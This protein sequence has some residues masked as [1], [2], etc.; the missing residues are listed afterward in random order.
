VFG[1][2]LAIGDADVDLFLECEHLE[3]GQ[4]IA[5]AVDGAEGMTWEREWPRRYD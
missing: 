1:L 4:R 3:D 2:Q 5:L